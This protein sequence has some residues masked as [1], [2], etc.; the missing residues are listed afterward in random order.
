LDAACAVF[1]CILLVFHSAPPKLLGRN[2]LH[3]ARCCVHIRILVAEILFLYIC[4]E[5]KHVETMLGV[6]KS[7]ILGE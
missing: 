2:P 4:V 1:G 5:K 3:G 7:M 6:S